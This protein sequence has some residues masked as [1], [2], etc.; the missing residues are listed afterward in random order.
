MDSYTFA[1]ALGGAGLVAMAATGL[2]HSGSH[3]GAG[4]SGGGH[5]SGGHG[6]LPH[7]DSVMHAG[8]AAGAHLHAHAPA[9]HPGGL[10][11][12]LLS[13][14][15]PRVLFSLL[16]GFGLT[17]VVARPLLSGVVLLAVALLGA[18]VFERALVAPLWRFLFRFAS[19]PATTLE[20]SLL[21]E[22][23]AASGFDD[24]GQG[25][26]AVEVDGQIVQ[27]L[28][29]LRDDDRALG[30]RVRA[31]DVLRVEQVDAA[32]S[33]CTVSYIGHGTR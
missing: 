4:G 21:S 1:L 18:V 7:G 6:H 23:R 14:A 2:A 8:H 16:V 15:S 29:T 12:T 20:G 30:V 32:R 5:D 13:L 9:H 27:C 33:R 22:A 31:G 11:S 17:G 10:K 19:N 24:N 26:V 25:L 3:E 28:G